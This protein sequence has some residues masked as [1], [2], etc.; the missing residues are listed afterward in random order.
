MPPGYVGYLDLIFA[1]F[2]RRKL[3]R[4]VTKLSTKAN[5]ASGETP[6]IIATY[7]WFERALSS[8]PDGRLVYFNLDDYVLYQP[9]R[10]QKILRQEAELVR[11]AAI[12]LCLS[13]R[14]VE[15]LQARYSEK[16]ATIRH[17]PLGVREDYLNP[18]PDCVS[19]RQTV[20]YIGNVIDRV[21][22]RLIGAVAR[23]L[24]DITFLFLG[25]SEGFGGGGS[26][27]DWKQERAT[28]LALPNVRN[29]GRVPQE[30]VREHYW[31]FSIFWIP[32]ATDHAFNQ[33]A[34]PTKIMD[35]LASGRP[36]I[37]TDIP[38]SRLYPEWITVVQ[39]A[40]EAISAIRCLLG[41]S[42]D[43]KMER[44]QVD[45][46]RRHIWSRRAETLLGWLAETP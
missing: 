40:D 9:K 25:S 44:A 24:P 31:D 7:P 34:C 12:T 28:V 14:Q 2:L 13:Q 20:G 35:G 42:A 11:R 21:D 4:C 8:V 18:T 1:P 37:S 32:Y 39:S 5:R 3:S 26:R 15:N 19:R 46:A 17:F 30:A 6:W 10:A 27:P 43:G 33:A 29:F 38:E 16:A 36:V 23:A 41:R 22:W 45:F